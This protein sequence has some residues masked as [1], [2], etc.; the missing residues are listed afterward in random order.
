MDMVLK[1][2]TSISQISA[3]LNI[4]ITLTPSDFTSNRL[5]K[6]RKV[7]Q[8]GSHLSHGRVSGRHGSIPEMT[9]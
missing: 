3:P 5:R 4:L 8:I 7:D 9:L 2:P 6:L 1:C